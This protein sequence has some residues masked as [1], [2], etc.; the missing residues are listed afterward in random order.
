M[1]RAG[2]QADHFRW[3]AGWCA[4][5]GSPLYAH[6]LTQAAGD[7]EAGGPVG[8]VLG[9][10]EAHQRSAL[11]L[12]LMGSVHR[13]VLLG[14]APDLAATYP[15]AGGKADPEVAWHAFTALVE[16]RF[17]DVEAGI[18]RRVQTNEVGRSTALVG[19]FLEVARATGLPLRV[20]EVGASAGLNLRWDHFRYEA[21]GA[22]WGPTDSPVRLCSYNS[23]LPLPF[24]VEANVAERAGCDPD[25]V[26]A[27]TD[28]G[29]LTLLSYVWPD[30]AHRIR[31]LRSALEVAATVPVRVDRANLVDWLPERIGP[32]A[33]QATVVFHSIVMQY[34]S[35]DDH[36]TFGSIVAKAGARATDDAPLAWLRLEPKGGEFHVRLNRWP[37]GEEHHLGTASAHGQNVRWLGLPR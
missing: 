19:G 15:S 31:L 36:H 21:R 12:R 3:Q 17:D 22:T 8:R 11:G 10:R 27:A 34:L 26:D 9:D 24:D 2:E 13:L 35:K 25:P 6:L 7:I 5:L 23:D 32:V 16:E 30:Q 14:Q 33:G 4:S 37:G 1:T 29:R 28:E 20:L 18:D